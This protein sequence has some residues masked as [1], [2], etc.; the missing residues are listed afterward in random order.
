LTLPEKQLIYGQLYELSVVRVQLD[1]A[2]TREAAER[3]QY[4]KEKALWEE[5]L[6]DEQ[7]LTQI[8]GQ[9]VEVKEKE[10]ALSRDQ[11]NFYQTAYEAC[12]NQ[13]KRGFWC[14]FKKIVFL[15][16]PKCH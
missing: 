6:R 8:T 10:L 11:L 12:K 16:I 14:T 2:K 3:E 9:R 13:K 5:R 1:E 7:A 4:E 15:G